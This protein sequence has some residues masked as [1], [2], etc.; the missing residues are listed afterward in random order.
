MKTIKHPSSAPRW[1]KPAIL[2]TAVALAAGVAV[3]TAPMAS[4]AAPIGWVDSVQKIGPSTVRVSGWALDQSYPTVPAT[5]VVNARHLDKSTTL[6]SARLPADR[7]RTDVALVM[8]T[9]PY[10]GFQIDFKVWECGLY[11]ISAIGVSVGNT[12]WAP[13]SQNIRAR[14]LL[15]CNPNQFPVMEDA[16]LRNGPGPNRA[17]VAFIAF[18][19]RVTVECYRYA[20]KAAVGYYGK[21]KLWYRTTKPGHPWILDSK[22][23]TGSDRPVVPNQ[24]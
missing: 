12:A 1:R 21:T 14:Y 23:Y 15:G 6:A 3:A 9:T 17:A 11:D 20:D 8:N 4:A 10:H 19:D 24:C 22:I 5:V 13:L 18:G 7:V 16:W 2:A